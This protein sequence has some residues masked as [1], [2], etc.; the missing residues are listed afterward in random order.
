MT[1]FETQTSEVV[2]TLCSVNAIFSGNCC[3]TNVLATG[4]TAAELLVLLQTAFPA[5][6][7]TITMLNTVITVGI[8][9][10]RFYMDSSSRIYNNYWMVR[11]SGTNAPYAKLCPLKLLQAQCRL[12]VQTMQY[13]APYQGGETCPATG[14]PFALPV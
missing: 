8:E 14:N 10:G 2:M 11:L 13:N 5:T 9:R 4:P 12:T 1:D 7:W 6:S 3:G